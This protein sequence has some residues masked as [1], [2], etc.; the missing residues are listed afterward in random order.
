MLV[1]T[2][3]LLAGCGGPPDGIVSEADEKTTVA[4]AEKANF[5]YCKIVSDRFCQSPDSSLVFHLPVDLLTRASDRVVDENIVVSNR[6]EDSIVIDKYYVMMIDDRGNSYNPNF[7]GPNNYDAYSEK[8]PALVLR[9]GDEEVIHFSQQLDPNAR[10]IKAV[11]IFYRLAGEKDFTQ[12]V[13]SY[14]PQNIYELQ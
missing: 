6:G 2:L 4:A 9:R 3:T 14:R 7:M 13:V 10:S 8:T 12:V 1:I 5:K 11:R